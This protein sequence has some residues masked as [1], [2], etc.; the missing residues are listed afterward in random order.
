MKKLLVIGAG[1]ASVRFL[2]H[3]TRLSPGRYAITVVGRE[4]SPGYNRVLLSALLAGD[5]GSNDILLRDAH[6]YAQQN[7]N[8]ITG[9]HVVDLDTERRIAT[10]ANGRVLDYD[11]CVLATG[12]HPIRLPLPGMDKTGV[13]AFRDLNDVA[14]MEAMAAGRQAVAVIGGGLLG[15]EA[16]YGLARRGAKVTLV[17]VMDRLMERQLDAGAAALLK[18]ALER[19]GIRV[20]LNAATQAVEGDEHATGLRFADGTVLEAAQVVCAVGIRPNIDLAARAGLGIKRGVL[21]NDHLETSAAHVFALGECAEHRETVYGLVEPAYAQADILAR[22]LSGEDASF[23]PMVL[24]TNLKVSGVPV[25]SAGDFEAAAPAEAVT[26]RDPHNGVYRKIVMREDRLIGCILVGDTSD[27]LWYL[28]LMR[29]GVNIGA[30]RRS[31]IHGRSFAENA[32][33]GAIKNRAA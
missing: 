5:V 15:I 29:R 8:L 26:L 13:I 22:R 31:L 27:G 10:A 2:E 3:I 25:F 21:V 18:R 4:A 12:S 11:L 20:M 19:R 7:I 16:A 30:A 32:L 14:A 23:A 33:S 6:W 24:S 1:M 17:H 9:E 28:D